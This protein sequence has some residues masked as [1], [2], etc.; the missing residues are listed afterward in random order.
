MIQEL[1]YDF[2]KMYEAKPFLYNQS[3]TNQ[4]YW[5][6]NDA[7]IRQFSCWSHVSLKFDCHQNFQSTESKFVQIQLKLDEYEG[8]DPIDNDTVKVF[9]T[10]CVHNNI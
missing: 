7:Y 2:V 4:I 3:M 6:S 9:N 8:T 10:Q 5:E 1:L